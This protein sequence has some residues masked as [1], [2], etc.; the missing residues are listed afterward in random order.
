[1]SK[2]E[3]QTVVVVNNQNLKTCLNCNTDFVYNHKKQKYCSD[4]CRKQFWE[5]KN[6]RSFKFRPKKK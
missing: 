2:N 4:E 6:G 5:A 1:M 3:G